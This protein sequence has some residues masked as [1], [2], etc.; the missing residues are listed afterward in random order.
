MKTREINPRIRVGR[1]ISRGPAIPVLDKDLSY[2]K[3]GVRWS[4]Q[5]GKVLL[6][7]YD[8]NQLI[9][10]SNTDIGTWMGIAGGLDEYR[11]KVIAAARER[12]QFTQFQAVIEAL[13]GKIFGRL[14][15]VYDQKTSGLSWSME[16]GQ[17]VLNGINVRSFLALYRVK[18]TE[19]AKKFLKGLKEKLVLLL[20]N[21]DHEK[22]RGLVQ[23]LYHEIS[24]ELASETPA[25]SVGSLPLRRSLDR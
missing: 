25:R 22:I 21:P 4:F 23:D 20:E 5:G 6:D 11:K 15:K 2:Y 17:L 9:S 8:V 18:K 7:G 3:E 19:K 16:D 12:D 14:K 13:L 1:P 24:G 10:S